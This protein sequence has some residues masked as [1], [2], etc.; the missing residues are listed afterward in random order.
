MPRKLVRLSIKETSGVNHPAHLH[1]GWMIAKSADSTEMTEILDSIRPDEP[2]VT[3]I[4]KEES[5][6]PETQEDVTIVTPD[7]TIDD[8]LKALPADVRKAF[9][10]RE[11]KLAELSEKAEQALTKAAANEAALIE[12]RANRADENAITK[13]AKSW[14]NLNLDPSVVGPAFRRLAEADE[15]LAEVLTKALDSANEVAETSAVFS[16]VGS[17]TA[18][19][20]T[21]ASGKIIQLAK[22]RSA[23]T[24]ETYEKAF[25]EI[26]QGNQDLYAQ[27]VQESR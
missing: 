20:A 5:Q 19:V 26:V 6:M 17:A 22:A 3:E 4:S 1:E 9:E 25:M 14:P 18:P 7:A 11:A 13:V 15:T 16:E 24:G 23:E 12:E 8:V 10:D 27:H 21:D 2:V